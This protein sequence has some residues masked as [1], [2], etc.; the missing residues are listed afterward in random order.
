MKKDLGSEKK[1]VQKKFGPENNF[2][3]EEN[4]MSVKKILSKKIFWVW[5]K[6]WFEFLFDS[7]AINLVWQYSSIS[8]HIYFCSWK[9]SSHHKL[10]PYILQNYHQNVASKL[11]CISSG[12]HVHLASGEQRHMY[13]YSF[14]DL[15]LGGSIRTSPWPCIR[16]IEL[17]KQDWKVEKIRLWL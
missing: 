12:L 1:L 13:T 9:S 6:V 4:S 2:W 8:I 10:I 5:K 7:N 3:P 17:K 14:Y 15:F 11:V 16:N